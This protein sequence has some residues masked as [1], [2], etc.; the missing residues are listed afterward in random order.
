MMKKTNTGQLI[1]LEGI[2]GSGKT[3]QMK[4][5]VEYLQKKG[6]DVLVMDFPQYGTPSAGL[7]EMYLNG[8]FGEA[9]DVTPYQASIFYAADRFAAKAKMIAHLAKG[10]VI[11]SNRYAT[12][13][14]VH[15]AG[16]I[17]DP[18][19]RD[20]FLAWLDHLEYELFGIPRP[21]KVLF[22]DV[23]EEVSQK[24]VADKQK[25]DYLK[26]DATHDIHERDTQHLADAR[27]AARYVAAKYSWVPI[28]SYVNGEMR[29]IADIHQS[30]ILALL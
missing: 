19:E 1:V 7:V 15:Q 10:G 8:A 25:R 23:P 21:T 5:L 26:G 22:F 13:N 6:E 17:S 16:K 4:L 18:A 14:A 27:V 28:E 29:S 9:K 30:V 3:T 24:L 11:V 2:D 20:T 12:A